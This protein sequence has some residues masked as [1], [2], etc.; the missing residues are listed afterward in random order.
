MEEALPK[1]NECD[2]E[3]VSRLYKAKIGVGCDGFHTKSSSGLEKGNDRRRWNRVGNGRN[4]LAQQ[5]SP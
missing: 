1:P 2:V 3:K 4:K 5:C